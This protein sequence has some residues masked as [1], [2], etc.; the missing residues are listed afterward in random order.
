M[1]IVNSRKYDGT[2]RRSW[3]CELIDQRDSLLVLTGEFA[4]AVD[5]ADLGRIEKGTKSYEYYWLDRWYN[6]FRFH[7]PTG[8]LKSYY[9]NLNMPPRLEDGVLDYVDLDIDILVQPDMSY[10]ILDEIDYATHSA[11]YGYPPELDKRVRETL[12]HLVESIDAGEIEGLPELFG[13]SPSFSRE[14]R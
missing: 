11:E 13:T 10:V 14:I 4:F 1:I 3:T 8:E 9:F 12:Q 5:H 2:I 7:E 6:V